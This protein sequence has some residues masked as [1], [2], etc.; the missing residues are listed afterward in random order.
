[1]R[2]MAIKRQTL[3]HSQSATRQADVREGQVRVAM[4]PSLWERPAGNECVGKNK[5]LPVLNRPTPIQ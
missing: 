1:M 5:P 3:A 4:R 2:L